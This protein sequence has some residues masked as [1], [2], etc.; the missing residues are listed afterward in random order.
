MLEHAIDFQQLLQEIKRTTKPNG[1]II[2][3]VPFV[4]GEHEA[5]YD[6]RRFTRFGIEQFASQHSL[7]ILEMKT[8]DPGIRCWYRLAKS[9]TNHSLNHPITSKIFLFLVYL[10]YLIGRCLSVRM[11]RIY[12]T[13]LVLL[14][15]S[16]ASSSYGY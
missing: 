8:L 6:Y 16:S 15:N 5:P 9:E 10:V 7:T 3:S 2:I 12:C 13:S 4:W 11:N 1:K 14:E